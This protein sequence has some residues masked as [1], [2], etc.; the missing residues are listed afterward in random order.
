MGIIMKRKNKKK[1]FIGIVLA[2][3]IIGIPIFLLLNKNIFNDKNNRN[4]TATEIEDLR[5]QY[6]LADRSSMLDYSDMELDEVVEEA[7]AFIDIEIVEKLPNYTTSF[8]ENYGQKTVDI[9]LEF[10][11][12]E[13]KIID[14]IAS[15][16]TFTKKS[17][18]T[19]I[20]SLSGL[21]KNIFPE[22]KEGMKAI[23]PVEA[24]SGPHE[25]KYS[26]YIDT[27]YYVTSDDYILSA[28]EET[29]D[30]YKYTGVK[31]SEFKKDIKQMKK[32][33][34]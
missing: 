13:L 22:L 24:A 3:V 9:T 15:D 21:E 29:N 28:Y 5:E 4:L 25:G 30:E 1:Y 17:G 20:L 34:K 27:F 16:G 10:M 6:P 23:I 7:Q 31:K 2:F 33:N 18:E 12:Y 8:K 14:V 11:Q 19:L 32:N 26:I